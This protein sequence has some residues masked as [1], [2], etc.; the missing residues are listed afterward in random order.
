MGRRS[1]LHVQLN[2][3]QGVDGIEVGGQVTPVIEGT[4]RL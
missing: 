4:L 1:I 2:G 3:E